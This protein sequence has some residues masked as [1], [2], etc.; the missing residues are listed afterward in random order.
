MRCNTPNCKDSAHHI[1]FAGIEGHPD[2][3]RSAPMCQLHARQLAD[4]LRFKPRRFIQTD[5]VPMSEG[6]ERAEAKQGG[7]KLSNVG[8]SRPRQATPA[9]DEQ[10]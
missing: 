3:M 9:S 5:I 6:M 2:M 8:T 10:K 7:R 1:V 4:F